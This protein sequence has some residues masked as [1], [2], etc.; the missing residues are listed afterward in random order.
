MK[1]MSN[2][3]LKKKNKQRKPPNNPF[4]KYGADLN[5]ESSMEESL[6]IEKN[7]QHP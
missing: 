1:K 4:K 3:K 6:M 7:F 2:K 5:R